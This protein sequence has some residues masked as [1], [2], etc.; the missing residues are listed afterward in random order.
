MPFERYNLAYEDPCDKAKAVI[1][2]KVADC[3][4]NHVLSLLRNH[5]F[6]AAVR[7]H[8]FGSIRPSDHVALFR[9][10]HCVADKS[11]DHAEI[12][13]VAFKRSSV[14]SECDGRSDAEC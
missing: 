12:R 10:P 5:D 11:A 6:V 7:N 14:T 13:C 1:S 9:D 2:E 8:H 3:D 4:C